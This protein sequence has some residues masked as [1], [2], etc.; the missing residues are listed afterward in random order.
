MSFAFL[1]LNIYPT[2]QNTILSKYSE[3]HWEPYDER[4]DLS[5]CVITKAETSRPQ[6]YVA[7]LKR[8]FTWDTRLG[9]S[10]LNTEIL[11][12][13]VTSYN[14]KTSECVT[15]DVI[16]RIHKTLL[17]E[18]VKLPWCWSRKGTVWRNFKT[19]RLLQN[20]AWNH[21]Y[22]VWPGFT[23]DAIHIVWFQSFLAA[24]MEQDFGKNKIKKNHSY[25]RK[26]QWPNFSS[27][28][29]GLS[30]TVGRGYCNNI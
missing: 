4:G 1:T 7:F 27:K 12:I 29:L 15:N 21:W 8:V 16:K 2:T 26:L 13:K 6:C 30:I 11:D 5:V 9:D 3:K 18:R 22:K 24:F 28:V 19:T 10:V 17:T 23:V 14:I 20:Q 25:H